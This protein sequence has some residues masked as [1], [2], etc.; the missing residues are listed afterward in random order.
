MGHEIVFFQP[1]TLENVREIANMKLSS[2]FEQL[3]QQDKELIIH[4]QAMKELCKIGYDYEYGARNLER[5]LRRHLLDKLAEMALSE[6]WPTIRVI[7]ADW[8]DDEIVLKGLRSTG[9][10]EILTSTLEEQ[11]FLEE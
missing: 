8:Q 10:Q 6:E 1:L 7:S 9:F 5:V 3:K 4:D 2:I 11:D